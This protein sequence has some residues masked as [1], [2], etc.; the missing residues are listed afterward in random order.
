MREGELRKERTVSGTRTQY[1]NLV[2][3]SHGHSRDTFG[4]FFAKA[5]RWYRL[6][7]G[8]QQGKF[9]PN[10]ANITVPIAFSLAQSDAAKKSVLICGN[11]QNIEFIGVGP[12]DQKLARKRTSLINT[13]LE[14]ADTFDKATQ[15]LI[16]A[17]IY[18]TAIYKTFWD[19]RRET[20]TFRADLGQGEGEFSSEELSFDGPN[21]EPVSIFNFF[22]CPGFARIRDMPW[23][24]ERYTL[25]RED[26]N[27]L[28]EAGFYDK[29]AGREL[30]HLPGGAIPQDLTTTSDDPASGGQENSGKVRNTFDKPVEILEYWGRVP[31][32]MAVDGQVNLVVTVANRQVLLR[33]RPNPHNKIPFGA[34]SPMPDPRYFHGPS[35]IETIEKLQIATN[36]FASQKADVLS[37]FADP[38]F[39]FNRRGVVDPRRLQSRPGK[40]HGFDGEVDDKQ[41]RPVQPDLR[42]LTNLYVE[43]EQHA[44]WM[45]RGT[46]IVDDTVQGLEPVSR[47]T[48]RSFLGRQEASG[49]RLL[50]EAKILEAL[51]F[52]PLAMDFVRLNRQF[53]TFPRSVQMMGVGA[54]LDPLTL[55]PLPV[56]LDVLYVN[57]MLPDYTARARGATMQASK[58]G[59]MQQLVGI[60]QLAMANPAAAMMFNWF[61]YFRELLV[62]AG[63]PNPDEILITDPII[64][65]QMQMAAALSGQ[66]LAMGVGGGGPTG[67]NAL[68]SGQ[69]GMSEGS[70]M[71]A[72]SSPGGIA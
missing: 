18:G 24:V 6:Y 49:T 38:Q 27:R 63:V 48:A 25:E 62:L 40:W 41:V 9:V 22:P 13:Q 71:A 33:A 60:G 59:M 72:A 50:M 47:E 32:S 70:S 26:V 19:V 67:P 46:G 53:L 29:A 43:L 44:K 58:Q 30:A 8:Y 35:K 15:F 52:E 10:R 28:I 45:E 51:W 61:I 31:R 66:Q 7:R 16:G 54:F 23:V 68:P 36:A 37:L 55:Q 2:K 56:G 39:F 57:D 20:V 3:E 21:W 12:E 34:V 69:G 5:S 42:A 1:V 4:P 14:D 17:A 64:Q 65:Q 11:P